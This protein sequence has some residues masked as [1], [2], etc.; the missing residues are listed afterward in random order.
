MADSSQ[1][2]LHPRQIPRTPSG[3]SLGKWKTEPALQ[4][5]PELH[6]FLHRILKSYPVYSVKSP[7]SPESFPD[8]AQSPQRF[9]H[10]TALQSA[11]QC[12]VQL[13]LSGRKPGNDR[14][15]LPS[16][17]E[18]PYRIPPKTEGR[19]SFSPTF[20]KVLPPNDPTG[21]IHTHRSKCDG[22]P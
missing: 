1:H 10:Q 17:E 6:D 12:G 8:I 5:A 18:V 7:G 2:P 20:Q 11:L 16:V 13:L 15:P 4:P 21:Q 14:S 22:F 9:A 3:A 19:I